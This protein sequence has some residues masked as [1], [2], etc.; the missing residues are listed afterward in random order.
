MD[1]D[2]PDAQIGYVFLQ[3]QEG[4][5]MKPIGYW[6]HLL[7]DAECLYD[8]THEVCFVV[9]GSVLM[10]KSYLKVSYFK[11]RT[12]GL[13][14][15][16]ILVLKESTGCPARWLLHLLKIDFEVINQPRMIYQA[17]DAMSKYTQGN[18]KERNLENDDMFILDGRRNGKAQEASV[19]FVTDQSAAM[20][21]KQYSWKLNK[22]KI[23]VVPKN[24]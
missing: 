8:T 11:I 24:H 4:G 22:R 21:S 18:E 12:N 5:L 3:D 17:T 6:S 20:P 15:R 16:W 10:L 2:E 1:T 13:A 19:C 7:C 23:S 9:V 14:L